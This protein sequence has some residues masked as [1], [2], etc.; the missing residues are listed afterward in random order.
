MEEYRQSRQKNS[1]EALFSAW[2]RHSG[3]YIRRFPSA[4]KK[5]RHG[6]RHLAWEVWE[7]WPRKLERMCWSRP[8]LTV[9]IQSVGPAHHL[10]STVELAQIAWVWGM[11][12]WGC[13][14][15][16][17]AP[18]PCLCKVE[19]LTLIARDQE[20]EWDTN[21]TPPRPRYKALNWPRP[22]STLSRNWWRLWW[23]WS[24]SN[25]IGGSPRHRRTTR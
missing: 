22:A 17:A 7:S 5:C 2:C 9:A 25:N 4:V 11:G 1:D 8:S 14:C 19:E 18:A 10:G 20:C 13:E 15:R 12:L 16:R 21:S 6:I 23:G 24:Y 3:R